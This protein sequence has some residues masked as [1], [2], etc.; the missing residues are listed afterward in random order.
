MQKVA[1]ELTLDR[2]EAALGSVRAGERPASAAA[3]AATAWGR[4]VAVFTQATDGQLALLLSAL[5]F[6]LTAWPL[7]LVAVPPF[8]DLPN[9]LATVTVIQH[10]AQYPEFVFN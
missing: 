7:L 2:R 4:L 5:L 10:P 9:H 3:G 8:Q 6:V 1:P